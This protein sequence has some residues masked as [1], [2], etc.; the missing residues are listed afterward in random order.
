V[1]WSTAE[2]F[3]AGAGTLVDRASAGRTRVIVALTLEN[4]CGLR[5]VCIVFALRSRSAVGMLYSAGLCASSAAPTVRR[6]QRM[7][8]GLSIRPPCRSVP[9]TTA[10]DVDRVDSSG[11]PRSSRLSDLGAG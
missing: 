9:D 7:P 8:K 4:L 10:L 11:H 1:I 6:C 5:R 3:S 2:R